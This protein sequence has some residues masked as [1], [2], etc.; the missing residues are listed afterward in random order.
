MKIN[1]T[2]CNSLIAQ[3]LWKV[4]YYQIFLTILLQE[5]KKLNGN[6]IKNLKLVEL[7]TN[8]VTA[9]LKTQIFK[10]I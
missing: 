1:L 9:F 4:H 7:N 6:M 2:D 10:M 5:F 3:N 8:F